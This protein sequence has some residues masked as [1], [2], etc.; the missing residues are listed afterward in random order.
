MSGGCKLVRTR[1]VEQTEI[2]TQEWETY[3]ATFSRAH[4]GWLITLATIATAQFQAAPE[5]VSA[6]WQIIAD[7]IRFQAVV[8]GPIPGSFSIT[9]Q[10]PT[11]AAT[12]EHRLPG[13]VRLFSLTVDGAHQGLRIDSTDAGKE[14][15]TLIWFEAPAV[16]E[17]LD[18]IAEFEM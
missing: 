2:S 12:V 6:N 8:P 3:C 17:E 14:E 5:R 1:I 9:T 4:H 15:S 11:G 16:P 13:V 18:G 10:T 7:Q